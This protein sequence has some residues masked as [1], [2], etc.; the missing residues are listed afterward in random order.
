MNTVSVCPPIHVTVI[1]DGLDQL[2]LQVLCPSYKLK[3]NT[4]SVLSL[5][6][7][8]TQYYIM[9]MYIPIDI[10]ECSTNNGGCH[11]FSNCTNTLG[12]FD[13]TC[14]DGYEFASDMH[15]CESMYFYLLACGILFLL[16]GS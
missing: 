2:V 14:M 11:T 6:V 16:A 15:T 4:P 5:T 9:Y 13:C 1:A 8:H 3:F 10:D 12:S 7:A